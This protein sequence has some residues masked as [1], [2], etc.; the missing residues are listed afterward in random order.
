MSERDR[1]W[2]LALGGA[3]EGSLGDGL[4]GHDAAIDAA[5]AA[6]Y[7]DGEG[8]DG[9]GAGRPGGPGGQSG[10]RSSSR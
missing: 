10:G 1:R 2:R 9:R 8:T 7:E 4:S 3:A 6:L 5:L